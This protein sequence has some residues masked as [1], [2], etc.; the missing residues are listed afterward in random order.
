MGLR[1]MVLICLGAAMFTI[2]SEIF[3]GE[4]DP[5][6]IAATVVTGVGFLGAGIILRHRG[7]LFGLTTAATVWL[8]AA[9]GMGIGMGKY[10]IVVAATVLV[11]VALWVIPALD[12]P[13]REDRS[14]SRV[15]GGL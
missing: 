9:L 6:C 13:R 15:A 7:S 5:R 4:G 11:L 10:A 1:T 14:A 2:F 12:S 3:V 8:V